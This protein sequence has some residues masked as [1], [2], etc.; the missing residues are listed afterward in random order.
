MLC[1]REIDVV[2]LVSDGKADLGREAAS[3]TAELTNE[4]I[5]RVPCAEEH[6]FWRAS[7][8]LHLDISTKYD[9]CNVVLNSL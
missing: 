8:T 2:P 7:P 1:R 5:C 9:R 4:V 3:R 6:S